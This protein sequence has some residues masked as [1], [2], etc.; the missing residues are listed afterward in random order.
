MRQEPSVV[1]PW[2]WLVGKSDSEA[3]ADWLSEVTWPDRAVPHGNGWKDSLLLLWGRAIPIATKLLWAER[4][5]RTYPVRAFSDSP[6]AIFEC[7][8]A[9]TTCNKFL[10][11]CSSYLTWTTHIVTEILS[12]CFNINIS[13]LYVRH[14]WSASVGIYKTEMCIVHMQNWW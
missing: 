6:L 4:S 7:G 12:A 14:N 3:G 10:L 8:N 1:P 9:I 11:F 13:S 5:V 2:G